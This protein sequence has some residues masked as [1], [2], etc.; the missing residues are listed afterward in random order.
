MKNA[1]RNT[2]YV[3]CIENGETQVPPD[4]LA[5]IQR[6]LEVETAPLFD[7]ELTVYKIQAEICLPSTKE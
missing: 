1:G 7:N 5:R 4:V 2:K 3:S 6:F